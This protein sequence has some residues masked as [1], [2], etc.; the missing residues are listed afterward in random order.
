[1]QYGEAKKKVL[2]LL[3]ETFT[4]S[5][6][7]TDYIPKMPGYFD[8][9]Q[10]EAALVKP[11]RKSY[12]IAQKNPTNLLGKES[13]F[14]SLQE[15]SKEDVIYECIGANSYYFEV[16]DIATIYIEE[17]DGTT[18]GVV[19]E[20]NHEESTP[21]TYKGIFETSTD[22]IKTRIRFSGD[23]YYTFRNVAMWD[24]PFSSVDKI[25][26]FG[27]FSYY[28]MPQDFY[29]IEKITKDGNIVNGYYW[30]NPKLLRLNY[31]DNGEYLVQYQAYPTSID[32][33]TP[34]EYEFEVDIEAQEALPYYVAAYCVVTEDQ[35]YYVNFLTEFR[36][37]LSNFDSNAP[38]GSGNNSNS[39]KGFI[40]NTFFRG[41][42][43]N[44]V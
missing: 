10:K 29:K 7:L 26:N 4:S 44:G 9:A 38:L 12:V 33:D 30:E 17:M 18:W 15:H 21:K 16:D 37:K 36:S 22:G 5:S 35:Q 8:A 6:A 43:R 11:I 40:L 34:D 42:D 23:Y 19:E 13:L 28:Q 32:E 25:P 14:L 31:Y 20:I 3:D 1:M 2:D 27:E 41:C 39:N 24:R